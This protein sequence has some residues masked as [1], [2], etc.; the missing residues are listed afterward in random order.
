MYGDA[1]FETLRVYGGEPFEWAAH[2]D[3]LTRTLTRLGFE[4]AMPPRDDLRE[5]VVE[6]VAANDFADCRA[7]L[8]ISRGVQPGKLTP[9]PRVDPTVVVTVGELPRGGVEGERV[10]D[11]PAAVETVTT[12]KPDPA[13]LPADAK[14][15]N[16]L[17]GILARLELRERAASGRSG[18]GDD[19]GSGT[20]AGGHGGDAGEGGREAD[21]GNPDAEHDA[22][23]DPNAEASGAAEEALLLDDEGYLTEGTTSNIFYVVD[24][25]LQTPS[26]VR[27]LLPGVTRS[28]VLDIAADESFPVQTGSHRP[29]HL[30][31]ADEVF[32]TNSSWE[33]R[34]VRRVDDVTFEVGPITRLLQRLFD[35]RVE[36][37]HY[38]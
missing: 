21:E 25:E 33:V 32:L 20:G 2:A 30:V 11:G 22:G 26:T 35:E 27:P 19:G 10:W 5:R 15:H 14:T 36:R 7:K 34:P 24:G 18:S 16:Y 17:N 3:R 38:G 4:A 13:A 8:S 1:A 37:R 31:R 23:A 6:T 9:S 12:R 29:N 28:V